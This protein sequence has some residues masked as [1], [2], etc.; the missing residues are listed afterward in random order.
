[1]GV[2][3]S[4]NNQVF[5]ISG[6]NNSL[7][8][9]SKFNHTTPVTTS[10]S[11]GMNPSLC[12]LQCDM[13]D[14]IDAMSRNL[15]VAE[16]YD[17]DV[18]FS[19]DF[20]SAV[21]DDELVDFLDY[22]ELQHR[23]FG[24]TRDNLSSIGSMLINPNFVTAVS[25]SVSE[26]INVAKNIK[27][28]KPKGFLDL[29]AKGSPHIKELFKSLWGRF[30]SLRNKKDSS[31]P[32][33]VASQMNDMA[34]VE[35]QNES[36]LIPRAGPLANKMISDFE[37]MTI[38]FESPNL[39]T[40]VDASGRTTYASQ[41]DA[42][43]SGQMSVPIDVGL[44]GITSAIRLATI[45]ELKQTHANA[46][47]A[48]VTGSTPSIQNNPNNVCLESMF[49]MLDRREYANTLDLI[50]MAGAD[51]GIKI[52]ED[53]RR[54]ADNNFVQTVVDFTPVIGA[55]T[56]GM[57]ERNKRAFIRNFDDFGVE[58]I[59]SHPDKIPISEV[60]S[61]VVVQNQEWLEVFDA[62]PYRKFLTQQVN[63]PFETLSHVSFTPGT[64]INGIDHVDG[65]SKPVSVIG[66]LSN[67][68]KVSDI[69]SNYQGLVTMTISYP[70]PLP[71]T[72]VGIF[73][74]PKGHGSIVFVPAVQTGKSDMFRTSFSTNVWEQSQIF[75]VE[76]L[77]TI[78]IACVDS[79]AV[80]KNEISFSVSEGSVNLSMIDCTTNLKHWIINREPSD[81]PFIS[82]FYQ[83][84]PNFL[85]SKAP[86]DVTVFWLRFTKPYLPHLSA[87]LQLVSSVESSALIVAFKYCLSNIAINPSQFV[88]NESV[89][90]WLRSMVLDFANWLYFKG[91]SPFRVI[92]PE[93]VPYA[94]YRVI[95][96]MRAM[97][98]L[99]VYCDNVSGMILSAKRNIDDLNTS[100]LPT[101]PVYELTN[102]SSS[103]DFD[104]FT[105]S[106]PTISRSTKQDSR[107]RSALESIRLT[108]GM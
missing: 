5:N 71:N 72:K 18:L 90:Q 83:I 55:T 85:V 84:D 24:I 86:N 50:R 99:I 43:F 17:I 37:S 25:K 68:F 58:L 96:M 67:A 78:G 44:N 57:I 107:P 88:S 87:I 103:L 59:L 69:Y 23:A 94:G 74:R 27:D 8:A 56:M 89:E 46:L 29:V 22:V 9:N 19:E 41:S 77:F 10:V 45:A 81:V 70:N 51:Y 47:M 30:S 108:A 11:S 102:Y 92:K 104:E 52:D 60:N 79:I 63:L 16:C 98:S 76:G 31:E 82:Y 73:G 35:K 95:S 62:V 106:Y 75:G 26:I 12:D 34:D 49:R 91:D 38:G 2:S 33:V 1:M 13:Y 105:R 21:C 20:I 39:T 7:D 93:F 80:P 66:T 32:V 97:I 48:S 14:I 101:F 36:V 54:S 15:E 53:V 40:L 3:T 28:S 42:L 100:S 4:V 65:T 64:L 6:S 61:M